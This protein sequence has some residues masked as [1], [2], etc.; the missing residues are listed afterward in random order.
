VNCSSN[1]ETGE[2][3]EIVHGSE[4]VRM[5]EWIKENTHT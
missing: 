2:G 5:D 4:D 1:R 3:E